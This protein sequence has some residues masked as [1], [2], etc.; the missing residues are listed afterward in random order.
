MHPDTEAALARR[1]SE[2]PEHVQTDS[3]LLGRRTVGCE[4]THGVFPRC[5][6][7]CTPCYHAK[8]AATELTNGERLAPEEDVRY[9]VF[10]AEQE[11]APAR[12]L[13]LLDELR[14]CI[15]RDELVLHYQ[16][17]VDL[18]TRETI[19]VEALIRWNHPSGCLLMP[20]DF[21]PEVE[22]SELMIPITAWVI[23][24]ALSQ[25]R[26]W[27]DEGYDLTMAVNVGARWSA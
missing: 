14:H 4:G 27:R 24:E 17:K 1:W 7:A 23:N 16:P 18:V 25:L 10:A 12:R 26:R 5:N 20:G 19:G 3:Q 2:L 15:E 11:E 6:L 21:I 13:A 8:E 9:G 22:G